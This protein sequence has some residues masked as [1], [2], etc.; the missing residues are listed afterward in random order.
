MHCTTHTNRHA[1][2]TGVRI[3]RRR[4]RLDAMEE[5]WTAAYRFT[6]MSIRATS[7][8]LRSWTISLSPFSK[9]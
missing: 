8:L 6:A 3:D 5:A 9:L 2:I 7:L 4:V 1:G